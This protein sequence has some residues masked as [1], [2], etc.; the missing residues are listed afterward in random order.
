MAKDFL[1]DSCTLACEQWWCCGQVLQASIWHPFSLAQRN[2]LVSDYTH[3][4]GHR[5]SVVSDFSLRFK[6]LHD[7]IFE[8]KIISNCVHINK[9][10]LFMNFIGYSSLNLE[11]FYY[12]NNNTGNAV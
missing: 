1:V 5:T 7:G 9:F 10:F 3:R 8:R 6:Q 12:Y 2:A 11:P 4:H